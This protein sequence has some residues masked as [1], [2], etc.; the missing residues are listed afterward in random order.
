[1]PRFAKYRTVIQE[2][3]IPVV[4]FAAIDPMSK[5]DISQPS[6]D[7]QDESEQIFS[8]EQ[9]K[10]A[11]VICR[12]WREYWPQY[13]KAKEWRS[14][15]LYRSTVAINEL[16]ASYRSKFK[17]GPGTEE[18][19]HMVF[20]RQG[21]ETHQAISAADA[22]GFETSESYQQFFTTLEGTDYTDEDL[23]QVNDF[24]E[25]VGDHTKK[26]SKM[27]EMFSLEGMRK[28]WFQYQVRGAG[29]LK[30]YIVVEQ[31]EATRIKDELIRLHSSLIQL[32]ST[33]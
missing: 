32:K 9:V 6:P 11:E 10:A 13:Q 21:P 1:M 18:D 8:P 28:L 31:R 20:W 14:T 27:K 25:E 26:I 33:G 15:P 7:V 4:S 16:C 19:L 30:E 2:C 12:I 3:S 17:Y 29:A 22:Q 5:V 24:F 23:E